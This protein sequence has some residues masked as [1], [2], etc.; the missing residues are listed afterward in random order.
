MI[1][2][3][4][5]HLQD[6][7]EPDHL[8][9]AWLG[10]GIPEVLV[11]GGR[12]TAAQ[13]YQDF[14]ADGLKGP[15]PFFAGVARTPEGELWSAALAAE[16]PDLQ[17]ADRFRRQLE[18]LACGRAQVVITGQQPGFM[19]GPLYTLYKA[20]TVVALAQERT[21]AGC[22]TFPVFWMGDDDDD[23][24]E[25]LSSVV[26]D[27]VQQDLFDSGV[28]RTAL[29]LLGS[30]R[31]SVGN[32]GARR[33][34]AR[35]QSWLTA[36]RAHGAD[37]PLQTSLVTL[38]AEAFRDNWTWTRLFRRFLLQLFGHDGLIV[39]SGNDDFLHSQAGPLYQEI[40][41]RRV[42]LRELTQ[43]RGETLAGA[44]FDAAISDRS[45]HRHLFRSAGEGREFLPEL[46]SV[47][48]PAC[49]R[50]GVMLRS[51]VQDWLFHPAAVVVGPGELAYLRQL[52]PVYRA[53]DIGRSPL[54]PR[55]SVQ[56]LPAD[57]SAGKFLASV[58]ANSTG[59]PGRWAEQ[60]GSSVEREIAALLQSELGVSA[61]RAQ[62]LAA[63]RRR[64]FQRALLSM[65][66]GER[67]FQRRMKA[68]SLPPWVLPRGK[69]QE[70]LLS[71]AGA[72]TLWGEEWLSTVRQGAHQ[73]LDLGRQG[74]WHEF[75]IQTP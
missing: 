39:V 70:R 74:T 42:A 50:P 66:Q 12:A 30:A 34:S 13:E 22:P 18:E 63:G 10:A 47:S 53:L 16:Y 55:L 56:C 65:F 24:S 19:G 8:F 60:V 35:G 54:V 6:T 3:P 31:T 68:A 27:P 49:L 61:E 25:A 51:P 14:L 41:A 67:D 57:I 2:Q 75:L 37:D 20:A 28:D 36:M 15:A 4:L 52:D 71:S 58:A 43:Q 9:A 62:D 5:R 1:M 40:L 33:F 59:R 17:C 7:V 46:A 38:W 26:W 45:L 32:L 64:R 73:H 11:E 48:T 69:R 21:Q 23:L 44:G 72:V 29:R